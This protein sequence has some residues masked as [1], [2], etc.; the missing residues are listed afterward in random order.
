MNVVFWS[1]ILNVVLDDGVV[2]VLFPFLFVYHDASYLHCFCV[3]V[4]VCAWWNDVYGIVIGNWNEILNVNVNVTEIENVNEIVY[5]NQ[6]AMRCQIGNE[7]ANGNEIENENENENENDHEKLSLHSHCDLIPV[8]YKKPKQKTK[9][10]N[11]IEA[12]FEIRIAFVIQ[13]LN[14]GFNTFSFEFKWF[15]IWQR[16]FHAT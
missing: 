7:I 12:L 4:C 15:H 16:P 14:F 1:L 13:Q 8:I 5:V 2:Y 3:C 11:Q 9:H 10:S 6:I